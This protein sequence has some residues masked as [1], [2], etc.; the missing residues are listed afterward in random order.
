MKRIRESDQT[1]A[2]QVSRSG[3]RRAQ[4]AIDDQVVLPPNQ[5]TRGAAGNAASAVT[6][7][8]EVAVEFKPVEHPTEPLDNDKPVRCPLPEPS[9]LNDGRIWKERVSAAGVRRRADMPLIKEGTSADSEASTEMS[10]WP[11]QS[12]RLILSSISAPEHKILNLLEEYDKIALDHDQNNQSCGTFLLEFDNCGGGRDGGAGFL[13]FSG[14]CLYFCHL[15]TRSRITF[16]KWVLT[17]NLSTGLQHLIFERRI[18]KM[19]SG[20]SE[21]AMVHPW[22]PLPSIITVVSFPSQSARNL[23]SRYRGRKHKEQKKTQLD[24]HRFLV[25]RIPT[26]PKCGCGFVFHFAC[27]W[28]D[29]DSQATFAFG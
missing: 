27:L 23:T 21:A 3:H 5:G 10:P 11:Q 13:L 16:V 20:A 8:I 17:M 28:V 24:H 4:S 12:S 14:F 22:L 9:I 25:C 26:P 18:D 19:F 2:Y 1:R 7:G 29:V 6:H 15:K